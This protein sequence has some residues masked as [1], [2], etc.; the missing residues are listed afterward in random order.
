MANPLCL[1]PQSVRCRTPVPGNEQRGFFLICTSTLVQH[2]CGSLLLVTAMPV[3]SILGAPV[4]G[5]MPDHAHWA[6]NQE[7]SERH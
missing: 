3:A 4:Y 5:F 7:P 1:A 2:L 6:T